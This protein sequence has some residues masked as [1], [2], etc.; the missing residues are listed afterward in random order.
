MSTHKRQLR[1]LA[2]KLPGHLVSP[3]QQ[4]LQLEHNI[5]DERDTEGHMA[6]TANAKLQLLASSQSY[7]PSVP[8]RHGFTLSPLHP[9]LTSA[10]NC[11]PELVGENL[12]SGT[13]V[14]TSESHDFS[15]QHL[16]YGNLQFQETLQNRQVQDYWIPMLHAP[17]DAVWAAMAQPTIGTH[18]GPSA[19]CSP[20]NETSHKVKMNTC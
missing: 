12:L 17:E 16:P 1:L 9:P 18:P 7:I 14:V 3:V 15:T 8:S 2:P 13:P 6:A 4:R 5:W 11:L 10:D 19:E 20:L